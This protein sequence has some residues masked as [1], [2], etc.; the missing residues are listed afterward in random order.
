MVDVRVISKNVGKALLVSA[1][2]MFFS[3][4]VS[5]YYGMDSAFGPL[6]ISCLITFI[7]G[8]FPSIFVGKTAQMS[9]LDGFVTV[10][11]SWVLSFVFGMLPYV[12]WGGEFS[13]INAWFESVSGYTTTGG[14]ILQDIE[15]LPKSL[16]FWRSSTHFIGGLGVV[17]FLLLIMPKA[18]QSRF[19]LSKLDMS[20]LSRNG[21]RSK[22]LKTVHIMVVVYLGLVICETLLL[23]LAGMSFFDAINHS[24]STV[25]TGGF[26]TRNNSIAYY[27][28]RLIEFIIIVFM[29]LSSLHLGS[30][31]FVFSKRSMH[32]LNNPVTKFFLGSCLLITVLVTFNLLTTGTYTNWIDAF[33]DALFSVSS[34]VSTTGFA[35]ADNNL[36]PVAACVLLLYCSVQCGCSGSTNGGVKSD[37]IYLM[38]KS[39]GWKIKKAVHPTYVSQV[40]V[41]NQIVEEDT[42]GEVLIFILFYLL[43]MLSSSVLL[44]LMGVGPEE[45]FSGPLTCMSNSGPGMGEIGTMG[46]YD[47]LPS[48]AK[49]L[50]TLNMLVGRVEL[51]PIFAVILAMFKRNSK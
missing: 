50:L 12:L 44:L 39:I 42:L 30:I 28:S 10:V 1:L 49:F 35:V 25:A 31:F 23:M 33:L 21:Y 37:R 2:F 11:L 20:T 36:W 47:G 29:L 6:A 43:I 15:G 46:N 34:Q 9:Q 32:P 41:G 18:S 16:V 4:I 7:V 22:S 45:A 13:L 17:V 5:L 40:K 3:V 8:V 48:P 26:S 14:T 27:D 51:F 38:F 24:F 19:K